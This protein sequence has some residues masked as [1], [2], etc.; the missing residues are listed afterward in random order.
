MQVTISAIIISL[1]LIEK[2][3]KHE[4]RL[5]NIK[6]FPIIE[7]ASTL[8]LQQQGIF[9][10]LFESKLFTLKQNNLQLGNVAFILFEFT[11]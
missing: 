6:N 2:A 3:W 4:K 7:A 11:V 1:S 10:K 9:E 5:K 8:V